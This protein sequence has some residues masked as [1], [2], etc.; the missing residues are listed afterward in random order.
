M[1][2]GFSNLAVFVANANERCHEAEPLIKHAAD[3]ISAAKAEIE[4]MMA[5]GN[6]EKVEA[7]LN[8]ANHLE[9]ELRSGAIAKLYRFYAALQDVK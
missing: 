6:K 7:L 9:A 5:Y 8:Q 3:K 2:G 1:P 4:K